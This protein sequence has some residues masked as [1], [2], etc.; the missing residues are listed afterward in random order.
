MVF[1]ERPQP[2]PE[3]LARVKYIGCL[4]RAIGNTKMDLQRT[5]GTS[6]PPLRPWLLVQMMSMFSTSSVQLN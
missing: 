1:K 4:R 2:K 5:E 3:S 6:H